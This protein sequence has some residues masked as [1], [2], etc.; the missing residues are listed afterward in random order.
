MYTI[1][2]YSFFLHLCNNKMIQCYRVSILPIANCIWMIPI[3]DGKKKGLKIMNHK[4]LICLL[5]SVRTRS[6]IYYYYYIFNW[7]K[8]L[9]GTEL[10]PP[11]GPQ[12]VFHIPNKRYTHTQ[13][14]LVP[15]NMFIMIRPII[16]GNWGNFFV[17]DNEL[18]RKRSIWMRLN[19]KF[20][21]LVFFV[22]S[23]LFSFAFNHRSSNRFGV[24]FV[25]FIVIQLNRLRWWGWLCLCARGTLC[26]VY[27]SN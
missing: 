27:T 14:K 6:Q 22:P 15:L 17:C 26:F 13:I 4:T 5:F 12:I 24:V 1:K 18:E 20:Q 19:W 16:W 10:G 3:W 11:T 21:M 25:R 7:N 23:L 2:E 9:N 8:M